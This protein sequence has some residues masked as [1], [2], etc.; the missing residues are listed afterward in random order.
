VDETTPRNGMFYDLSALPPATSRKDFY[1]AAGT[2]RDF[3]DIGED[4]DS[5]VLPLWGATPRRNMPGRT[6][7]RRENRPRPGNS[8]TLVTGGAEYNR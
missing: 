3:T 7:L 8:K 5:F 2:I 1:N 6:V 4:G